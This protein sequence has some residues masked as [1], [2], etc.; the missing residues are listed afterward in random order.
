MGF[1]DKHRS[2]RAVVHKFLSPMRSGDKT[3]RCRRPGCHQK[4]KRPAIGAWW[5]TIAGRLSIRRLNHTT[6]RSWRG[7]GVARCISGRPAAHARRGEKGGR[8]IPRKA[9]REAWAERVK[10][11]RSVSGVL[12]MTK[13]RAKRSK[14]RPERGNWFIPPE[15]THAEKPHPPKSIPPA[16]NNYRYALRS[17]CTG[18]EMG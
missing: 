18:R 1:G 17:D 8:G 5:V 12:A 11:S 3:G 2:C 15:P 6:R 9:A 4:A 10:A 16:L 14:P 13:R 7:E